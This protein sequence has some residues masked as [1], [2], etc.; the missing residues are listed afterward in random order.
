MTQ[1]NQSQTPDNDFSAG[2]DAGLAAAKSLVQPPAD[3]QVLSLANA[4]DVLARHA[5][6]MDSHDEEWHDN[7]LECNTIMLLSR[8]VEFGEQLRRTERRLRG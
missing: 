7:C 4:L 3:L 8:V 6:S 1:S 2:Y 5:A